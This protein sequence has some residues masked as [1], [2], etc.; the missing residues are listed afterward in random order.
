M[1][2][3]LALFCANVSLFHCRLLVSWPERDCAKLTPETNTKGFLPGINRLVAQ[4]LL[5]PEELIILCRPLAAAGSTG[6]DLPGVRRHCEIGNGD[7][8]GFTGA[9]RHD[10]R[11]A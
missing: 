9:V 3:A 10:G 11:V 7:I 5:D 1:V 8:F 4:F 2:L 6:L